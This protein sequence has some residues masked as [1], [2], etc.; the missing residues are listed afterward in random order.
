LKALAA[1]IDEYT[2]TVNTLRAKVATLEENNADLKRT[3]AE[4]DKEIA[5]QKEKSANLEALKGKEEDLNGKILSKDLL[6][7]NLK[8]TI[9]DLSSEKSRDTQEKNVLE[10]KIYRLEAEL[11]NTK[12][13]NTALCQNI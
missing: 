9:Q 7:G 8:Q 6:I 13:A 2:R 11:V 12:E 5:K 4:K 3:F 10:G 1:K